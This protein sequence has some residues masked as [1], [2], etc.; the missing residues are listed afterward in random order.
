MTLAVLDYRSA[1]PVKLGAATMPIAV[2]TFICLLPLVTAI[3]VVAI[4]PD[5]ADAIA[6]IIRAW[7]GRSENPLMIR[8]KEESHDYPDGDI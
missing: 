6:Q 7:H 3:I 8:Y 5:R 1:D 2:V 4:R